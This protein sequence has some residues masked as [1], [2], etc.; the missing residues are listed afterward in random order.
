MERSQPGQRKSLLEM[1]GWLRANGE[2]I[3]HTVPWTTHS[4]GDLEK[5]WR[6][7]RGHQASWVYD[8]CNADD[9]RYTRS[10]DGATVYAMTLGIPEASVTFEALN[11]DVGIEQCIAGRIRS[12]YSLGADAGRF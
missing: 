12:A 8:N 11:D 10:K 6:H 1:G 9:K 2:A 3:Y 7:A 4:E 5:L